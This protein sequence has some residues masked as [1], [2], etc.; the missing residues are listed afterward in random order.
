MFPEPTPTSVPNVVPFAPP[1]QGLTNGVIMG[2]G[3]HALDAQARAIAEQTNNQPVITGLAA[4]IR[5]AWV[6]NKR[7]KDRVEDRMLQSVRQRRGEYDPDKAAMIREQGG[8]EI[9]MM[10]SA[11]KARTISSWLREILMS[12]GTEK[13][14]TLDATPL[15]EP[16]PEWAMRVFQ[17]LQAEMQT[18]AMSGQPIDLRA[19]M[20]QRKAELM[21]QMREE[22]RKT[23]Q[24]MEEYMEDQLVEG[25]FMRSLSQFIDDFTTFPAA[26][27]KGPVIRNRSRLQ[28]GEDP[29]AVGGWAVQDVRALQPEWE[30]IDPFKLYPGPGASSPDEG[31][32]IEYHELSRADLQAMVGVDGY[33]E[34]AIRAVLD[35]HGSGG[36]KAWTS[37]DSERATAEGRESFSDN[38]SKI[39]EALQYWGSV[40]GQELIDWGLDESEVEDPLAEYEV[41][42]WLIGRWV[43]KAVI[44]PDMLG[45]RPYFHTSWEKL[46]GLFWGNSPM[47]QMRDVQAM[48]NAAARALANNMGISSGPQVWVNIDRLP[49]G[50]DITNLYPWRIW[51]GTADQMG[52]SAPPM[53]FFQPDSHANELM[54]VYE[55]FSQIADDVVG[56]PRYMAGESPGGGVGRTATGM[57]MLM[58]HAGKVMQQAV[59][60]I[61][62]EVMTPLLERLYYHNMKYAEDPAIKGDVKVRA[63][64]ATSLAVKES[65]QVRRNEFLQ[66]LLNSPIAQQIVGLQ[67]VATLLREGAKALDLNVDKI[68]PDPEALQLQQV[69]IEAQQLQQEA[70]L[71]SGQQLADGTETEDSFRTPPRPG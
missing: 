29:E 44:N 41:E 59:A 46:P 19:M 39:I 65:L 43:I 26:I 20:D 28:W 58:S 32:L 9:Y 49:P 66:I 56:V 51:Q 21:T 5:A 36:L 61:D 34:Q 60:L 71:G 38:P 55:K 6:I 67:G 17:E 33:S 14:W 40:R 1:A 64:G 3:Q 27:L 62:L 7:E 4:H 68:V 25:G 13:P 31:D 35:E 63:R 12:G 47:D 2:V 52:S 42:A 69:L 18:L 53:M 8:S 22:A 70:Q 16:P 24:R 57:S 10:I 15:P 37:L 48:C 45:R 54:A 30:R 50:E 23:A 11:A